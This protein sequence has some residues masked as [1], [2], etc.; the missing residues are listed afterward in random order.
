MDGCSFPTLL[1]IGT[2]LFFLFAA[3]PVAASPAAWPYT[4]VVR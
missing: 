3:L 4:E 2:I 1:V